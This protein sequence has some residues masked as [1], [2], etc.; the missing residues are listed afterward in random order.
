MMADRQTN[1]SGQSEGEQLFQG[2]DEREQV[3]APEQ[4]NAGDMP[5][6]EV[7]AGGTAASGTAIA[8]AET[9]VGEGA[10]AGDQDTTRVVPVRPDTGINTP[11]VAPIDTTDDDTARDNR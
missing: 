7:D 2:M 5:A 9:N 4:V 6:D 11:A 8:D 3:Y 10:N 1:T